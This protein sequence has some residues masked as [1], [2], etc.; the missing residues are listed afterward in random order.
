MPPQRTR[1]ACQRGAVSDAMSF[2]R[3]RLLQAGSCFTASPSFPS[4]LFPFF[5][6]SLCHLIVLTFPL[7]SLPSL[8]FSPPPHVPHH[9]SAL[10]SFPDRTPTPHCAT[11][12]R[13]VVPSRQPRP[14]PRQPRALLSPLLPPL[15]LHPSPPR[16]RR[17]LLLLTRARHG[18]TL[19]SR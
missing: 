7:S 8:N 3:F 12:S 4:S 19:T 9:S 10:L 14:R 5:R 2:V 11:A 6:P 15:L 13:S 17:R 16:L 1:Q 18:W